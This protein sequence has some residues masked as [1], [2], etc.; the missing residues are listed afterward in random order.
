[1]PE[2][3]YEMLDIPQANA[4]LLPAYFGLSMMFP[5]I[6]LHDLQLV[7]PLPRGL[8]RRGHPPEALRAPPPL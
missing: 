4:Q 6:H 5:H 7:R 3:P 1:M 2:L 8:P